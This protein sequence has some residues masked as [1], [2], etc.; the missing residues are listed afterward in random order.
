[1]RAPY[2]KRSDSAGFIGQPSRKTCKPALKR[3]SCYN[4][5]D[6]I[7]GVD[8]RLLDEGIGRYLRLGLRGGGER[9]RNPLSEVKT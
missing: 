9:W 3:P 1:M 8:A 5:C 2:S 7:I 6:Y 4:G